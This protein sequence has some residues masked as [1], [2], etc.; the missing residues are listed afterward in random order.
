M[1][2]YCWP[3]NVREL[4]NICERA[5][6]L[7]PGEVIGSDLIEPW[8]NPACASGTVEAIRNTASPIVHFGGALLNGNGHIGEPKAGAFEREA[9]LGV[10]D[11]RPLEEIE[12][13]AIVRTL[14]RFQGHR[15]KSASALGIGV[16][17]LGLK[18][19]KWK[20]LRLVEENL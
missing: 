5:A 15:Q 3:G 20:E 14:H 7:C 2:A 13:E 10:L 17:T 9:A 4:Q 8:L 12:R 19:K 6:V 16:R 11:G 18:L 1:Q